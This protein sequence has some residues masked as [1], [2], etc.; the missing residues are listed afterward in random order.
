LNYFLNYEKT[1]K[2]SGDKITLGFVLMGAIQIIISG[3]MN[4]RSDRAADL[5]FKFNF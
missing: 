3:F 4:Q 1:I 2:A 5:V